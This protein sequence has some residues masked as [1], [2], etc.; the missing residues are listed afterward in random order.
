MEVY[1]R[2]FIK[3]LHLHSHLGDQIGRMSLIDLFLLSTYQRHQHSVAMGI[4]SM[5]LLHLFWG[6]EGK[7]LIEDDTQLDSKGFLYNWP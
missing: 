7:G 3:S 5:T 1:K 6:E 2:D 4:S